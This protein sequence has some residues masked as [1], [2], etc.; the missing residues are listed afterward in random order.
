MSLV[1]LNLKLEVCYSYAICWLDPHFKM[2]DPE[3]Q[4]NNAHDSTKIHLDILDP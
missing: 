1:G 3:T 4:I 2:A